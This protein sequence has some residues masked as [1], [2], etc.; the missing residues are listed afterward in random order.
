M[1]DTDLILGSERV[2]AHFGEWP[3]FHD[4]EVVSIHMDR[5]GPEGPSI[6]FV[7]CA[8]GYTGR[9]TPEGYYEQ[10]RH[11]LIR[12]RCEQVGESHLEGFNHQ[13]VIDGLVVGHA[14]GDGAS[15]RVRLPSI[16]GVGGVIECGRVRVVDVTS[17]TPAGEPLVSGMDLSGQIAEAFAAT[18][19]TGTDFHD[20][21][22]T[23][24][25]E[26]IVE[27]FRGTTWRGH[28]VADLRRHCAAMSFFTGPA[29]RYWLPAFML[30]SLEDA[31]RAEVIPEYIASSMRR[32]ERLSLFT[33]GELGAIAAFL[34]H[35]AYA[36][37]SEDFR[38]T[39]ERVSV[40]SC[41]F[42]DDLSV[43]TPGF[44]GVTRLFPS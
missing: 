10:H 6:E 36:Y 44:F 28:P 14:E 41:W 15:I 31:K 21:S 34:R 43:E 20:I 12:F 11:A 40:L 3:S 37:G 4:M 38:E 25:D 9:V 27:Y 13:N 19:A 2:I 8:W 30:A 35:L 16:F 33:D 23:E 22:A 39:A 17:A 5:R 32:G 1:S 18:P 29:F 24:Q 26:G 7:I 42:V